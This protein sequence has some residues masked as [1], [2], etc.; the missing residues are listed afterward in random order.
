MIGPGRERIGLRK[1]TPEIKIPHGDNK[2]A[3][4]DKADSKNPIEGGNFSDKEG[5]PEEGEEGSRSGDGINERKI[6]YT[7]SLDQTDEIDGLNQ[8]REDAQIPEPGRGLEE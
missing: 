7:V 1:E 6:S 2:N 5:C 3:E 4:R 8:A